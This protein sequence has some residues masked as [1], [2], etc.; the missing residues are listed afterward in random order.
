MS[1]DLEPADLMAKL[2]AKHDGIVENVGGRWA[3]TVRVN[4]KVATVETSTVGRMIQI[5]SNLEGGDRV[6]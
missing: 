2:A 3:A 6:A 4:G 5:L 1:T